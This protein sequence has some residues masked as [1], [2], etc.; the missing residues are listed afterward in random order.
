MSSPELAAYAESLDA[1]ATLFVLGEGGGIFQMDV[2]RPSMQREAFNA[3]IAS[4]ALRVLDADTVDTVALADGSTM[5]VRRQA[6]PGDAP[7]AA[8]A[9]TK[10]ELVERAKALGVKSPAKLTVD[11]LTSAITEAEAALE[12]TAAARA[13]LEERA[14][15]LFDAADLDDIDALSDEQLAA[16]I[17]EAEADDQTGS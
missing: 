9:V 8:S 11:N 16:L 2:P 3:R 1:G 10:A 5:F 15:E 13:A 14:R 6:T 7:V 12:A 4:G 17:A